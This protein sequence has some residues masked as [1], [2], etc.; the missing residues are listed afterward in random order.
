MVAPLRPP[1]AGVR[2]YVHELTSAL[3]DLDLPVDLIACG[4]ARAPRAGVLHY[5]EPWHPPTNLGWTAVGLRKTARRAG[6][7][8]F[9]A[10]A[11]T[12]PPFG[13]HPLVV[14]LHD[15]SYARRPEWYPHASGAL[16]SWFY[17]ASAR[18][19]DVVITDST[20]SSGEI[21][22]AYGIPP[23]K[24]CVIPLGVAPSFT[25]GTP[26]PLPEGVHQPYFLHVGDLHERRNLGI[27]LDAVLQLRRRG[28]DVQL[29]LAGVDR[30]SGADLNNQARDHH[31]PQAV[32]VLGAVSEDILLS[33]YRGAAGL[34]YPS[35]YEGFG[36]PMVEA[37]ACGV[38]V[39]ASTG[40]TAEEIAGDAALLLPPDDV[41]GWCD[42]FE[43]ILKNEA[44][45]GELRRRGLTRARAF[46][47][48][49]TARA[50]WDAYRAAV[51]MNR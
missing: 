42:A 46:S 45:S 33:L 7:D 21:S 30:G 23:D 25:P 50:T 6:L 10:P 43:V 41:R 36:L 11:Y 31:D 39:V 26:G 40:S 20:F 8:V 44:R 3:I 32:T 38:P 2:R 15:V 14:T 47:W 34:A 19:A 1:A 35:R 27:A 13:V 22:A 16:R 17:R 12:A 29:V 49:R 18:A 28:L 9:H 24:I 48:E 51:D 4:G 5:S 37:M